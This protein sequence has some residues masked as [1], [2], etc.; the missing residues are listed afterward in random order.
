MQVISARAEVRPWSPARQL[1]GWKLILLGDF[2]VTCVKSRNVPFYLKTPDQRLKFH[3]CCLF[4]FP[5][6]PNL[7]QAG[8]TGMSLA[9]HSAERLVCLTLKLALAWQGNQL[10]LGLFP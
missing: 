5:Q 3:P 8:R 9:L 10:E 4:Y 1:Y 6:S 2:T 7:H